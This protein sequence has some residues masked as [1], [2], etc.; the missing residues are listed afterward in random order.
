MRPDSA[1]N[2]LIFIRVIRSLPAVADN[3][4]FNSSDFSFLLSVPPQPL[5]F[6]RLNFRFP[7]AAF[8][9]QSSLSLLNHLTTDAALT[10]LAVSE[11]RSA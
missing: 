9:F 10:K 8:R 2:S 5:N 3:P 7:L 11:K 6:Q 4:W 1:A